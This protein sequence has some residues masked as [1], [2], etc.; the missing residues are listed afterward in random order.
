MSPTLVRQDSEEQ[1]H[2]GYFLRMRVRAIAIE[3]SPFNI[4]GDVR[5]MV[6]AVNAHSIPT[7]WKCHR[8]LKFITCLLRK[9]IK[10]T[11]TFLI[12][13]TTDALENSPRFLY[14]IKPS[15]HFEAI[16]KCF[17]LSSGPNIVSRSE[18]YFCLFVDSIF[19]FV[20]CRMPVKT[21]VFHYVATIAVCITEVLI[22][23]FRSHFICSIKCVNMVR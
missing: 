11:S 20:N 21:F 2:F 19:N 5:H 12:T 13:S 9:R 3:A 22:G 1:L 4:I 14:A 8:H 15:N 6:F 16:R 7:S 18:I 23:C 10:F 17:S